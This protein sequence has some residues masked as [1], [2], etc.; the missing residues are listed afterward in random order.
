MGKLSPSV[1][2][3][4]VLRRYGVDV[5]GN[6]QRFHVCCPL[7]NE[8]TPSCHIDLE[9]QVWYCNGACQQGGDAIKLVM[10]RE[11]V[12]FP[13]AL[14]ILG[15][16]DQGA[17]ANTPPAKKKRRN[18]FALAPAPAPP[19]PDEEDAAGIAAANIIYGATIPLADTP[20]AWYCEARGIPHQ[21]AHESGAR[22]TIDLMGDGPA[23]VFPV[24]DHSGCLCAIQ[25][26]A[27]TNGEKKARGP[28]S[29]GLFITPGGLDQPYV[30]ATEG[31]F[32][33]LSLA[34]CSIPAVAMCG[35]NPPKWLPA[36][37]GFRPTLAATDNDPSKEEGGS[38]AG[39]SA[40][41]KLGADMLQNGGR[42]FRLKPGAGKDWNEFLL[43]AGVC[44]M[45]SYVVNAA[46]KDSREPWGP[47]PEIEQAWR[48]R[49][50]AARLQLDRARLVPRDY[51]L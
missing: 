48:E 1:N 21:V 26:R 44:E 5:P 49:I 20:G 46:L 17:G 38:E 3:V 42:V 45:E 25:G 47:M 4:D 7:H 10:L 32:D 8:R 24:Y 18:P 29:R 13:E 22:Y 28:K 2:L 16:D 30:I 14:R 36:R 40:A 41:R 33:A 27:I 39:Q 31:P 6:R 51:W 23:V 34:G 37:I 43:L 15:I 50:Q 9:K 11:R 35:L 12:G 19:P